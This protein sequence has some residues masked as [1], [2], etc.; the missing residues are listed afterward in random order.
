MNT[1]YI[2]QNAKEKLAKVATK[3]RAEKPYILISSF[4]HY[5]ALSSDG[6]TW[7]SLEANSETRQLT[8]NCPATKP[9][10]H[11]AATLPIH[12]NLAR[13]RLEEQIAA[14]MAAARVEAA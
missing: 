14:E 10:K 11:L 13:Q 12:V 7:Y 5:A 9:C 3:A 8:C 4:G 1:L 2:D 6:S